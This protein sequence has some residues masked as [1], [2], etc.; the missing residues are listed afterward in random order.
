MSINFDGQNG[1]LTTGAL[2]STAVDYAALPSDEIILVTATGKNI[3]LPSAIPIKGKRFT[4]KLTVP[5]IA[6]VLTS[7]GQTIDGSVDCL[8]SGQ[9]SLVTVMSDGANWIIVVALGATLTPYY[10]SLY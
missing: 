9:N 5:G 7:L 3:T 6:T 4:V 10:G 1:I 2:T 8:L